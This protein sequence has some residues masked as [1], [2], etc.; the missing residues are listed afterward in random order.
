MS[1]LNHNRRMPARLSAFLVWAL[2]A[3]SAVFWGLRLFAAGPSA[4]PQTLA[5]SDTAPAHAD[6]THLLGA[7][8]E[9]AAASVPSAAVSSRFQLTGVMGPKEGGHYG[10]AL[11]AV[12]GK[13]PK[14]YRVGASIDDDMVLQS[15]SLRTASIG[16]EGGPATVVLELP[17]LP[18]P[19]TGSLPPTPPFGAAAAVPPRQGVANSRPVLPPNGSPP[20][21]AVRG[22]AARRPG[23]TR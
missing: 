21:N 13:M 10:I 5:V 22:P 17:A 23:S 7:P 19:A 9:A 20:A 14:P 3:G 8:P 11:L 1:P 4:P 18:P 2:V 16:P 12:D 6:L 15:V